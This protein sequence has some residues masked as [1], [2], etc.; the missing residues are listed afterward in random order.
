MLARLP[1]HAGLT[2]RAN[3]NDELPS[4]SAVSGMAKRLL[5][6]WISGANAALLGAKVLN[7][8]KYLP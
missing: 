7:L 2:G 3:A 4:P 8:C 6:E 5:A 1:S